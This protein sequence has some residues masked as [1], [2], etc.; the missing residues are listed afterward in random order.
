MSDVAIRTWIS[1]HHLVFVLFALVLTGSAGSILATMAS[2]NDLQ[3]AVWRQKHPLL[4][5]VGDALRA[6]GIDLP[7]LVTLTG[8]G[9]ALLFKI[10]QK[11]DDES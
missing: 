11:K 5:F 1:T 6:T 9:L 10:L 2:K 3:I 8:A 4:A 7:K